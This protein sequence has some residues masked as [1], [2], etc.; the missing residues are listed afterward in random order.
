MGMVPA[1]SVLISGDGTRTAGYLGVRKAGYLGVHIAGDV[2]LGMGALLNLGWLHLE[3][4]KTIL[5]FVNM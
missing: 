1:P 4:K 3:N 2:R 5:N